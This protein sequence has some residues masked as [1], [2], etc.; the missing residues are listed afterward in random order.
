MKK[1][2]S[3][4]CT[5]TRDVRTLQL[6]H[7]QLAQR[8]LRL[9]EFYAAVNHQFSLILNKIRSETYSEETI[10]ALI[11]TYRN[12]ALFVFFIRGLNDK[13]SRTLIIQKPGTLPAAYSSCLEMQ[14]LSARTNTLNTNFYNSIVVA[15]NQI[16]QGP[17]RD[18][19]P[20]LPPR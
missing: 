5:A 4:H 3:L 10:D 14:N 15:M 18:Q 19:R 11:E 8:N 9:D 12:R 20:P 17:W 7:N 16:R 6:Q 2:L 1:I 13:F